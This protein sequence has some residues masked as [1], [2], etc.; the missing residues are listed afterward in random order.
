MDHCF[1]QL[2][3]IIKEKITVTLILKCKGN[4]KIRQLGATS[5]REAEAAGS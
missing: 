5:S 2:Y 3:K 1:K 4:N